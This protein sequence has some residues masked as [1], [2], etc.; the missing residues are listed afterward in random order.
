MP[1]GGGSQLMNVLD[2]LTEWFEK[3]ISNLTDP[4]NA[5]AKGAVL[6]G[7]QEEGTVTTPEGV[8][9]PAPHRIIRDATAH[10]IG[11]IALDDDCQER[12]STILNKGVPMPSE[13]TKEFALNEEG[14]IA[15]VIEVIQGKEGDDVK[16]CTP[17]G[18][19]ELDGLP[20]IYGKPHK[21]EIR[22]RIDKNG[23]LTATAHDANCGKTTDLHIQYDKSLAS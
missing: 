7:W 14:Q 21:I 11:I 4:Y 12:F 17:L 13:T 10:A 2:V 23:L 16:S 18:D 9:L 19:F 6:I 20:P 22:L 3:P 8:K 15:A 1:I 5:V